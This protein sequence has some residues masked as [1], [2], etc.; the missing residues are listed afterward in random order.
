[1]Y[2]DGFKSG[3]SLKPLFCIKHLAI[4]VAQIDFKANR[5]LSWAIEDAKRSIVSPVDSCNYR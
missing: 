4:N 3:K 2:S 1:M 5:K